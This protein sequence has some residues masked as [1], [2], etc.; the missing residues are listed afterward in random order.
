M[1]SSPILWDKLDRTAV[2]L[3]TLEE[4]D[5]DVEFWLSRTPAERWA[6]VEHLRRSFHGDAEIDARIPRVLELVEPGDG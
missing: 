6:G 4:A 1:S 2:R 5:D 3:M